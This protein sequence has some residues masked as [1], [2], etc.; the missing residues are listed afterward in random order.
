MAEGSL[1]DAVEGEADRMVAFLADFIRCRSPNPPGDTRDA[2]DHVRALLD[3]EGIDYRVID[4]HPEM[5]NIVAS[6]LGGGGDGPHL[7]LNGH[8]D[9]F[10]VGD[11]HGWSHDPWGGE[12]ADGKIWGRGAADMK[13]GTTA[14]IFT[15]LLLHRV[16]DRVRGRL[17]L[18]CVSDEETF[19]P[20]G[21]RYLHEHHS[22]EV[23]G[24]CCLNGEPGSPYTVRFGEKG[25]LWLA[26]DVRADGAHGAYAHVSEG[27]VNRAMAL[28]A[29]LKALEAIDVAPSDN[30][31]T[32]IDAAYDAM[33]VAMGEGAAD[34]IPKVTV[35]IG[36]IEGG[37]KVNMIADHCR[38]EVDIRQPI[39]IAKERLLAEVEA[40]VG[41]RPG[42]EWQ[43]MNDSPPNWCNPY[44]EMANIL[45]GTVSELKGFDPTPIVSLGTTDCRL[46]RDRGVPA[47]IYGPFPH[48]MGGADEHVSVDDF[49]HVVRVH[50][51]SAWRY[52]QGGDR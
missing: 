8:I 9:V 44:G 23:L 51:L 46:W 28:A 1:L 17:T 42:V 29:D 24:D 37:Q 6:F 13:A 38:M 36:R 14:S 19:G 47:Y 41:D 27:A 43:E 39:G 22:D 33:N 40:I 49:L 11:G 12:R 45:R 25:P 32:A 10:P 21:A 26:F 30:V 31:R 50:V 34:V 48:G 5:P 3:A 2:A 16:R 7:V 18:T 52:L 15:Y 20:Y 35:N 4:P